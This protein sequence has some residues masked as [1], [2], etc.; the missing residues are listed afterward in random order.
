MRGF[1]VQ[2]QVAPH[3]TPGPTIQQRNTMSDDKK[4]HITF[5]PGAFD[6]FEGTQEEL[7]AL[8]AEIQRMAESGE[9]EEHSIAIDEDDIWDQLTSDEQDQVMSAL[10]K[11]QNP[12]SLN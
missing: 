6:S 10:A 12:R 5:A 7:D 8:M 9:L 2:V 1:L 4:I 11:L 3:N